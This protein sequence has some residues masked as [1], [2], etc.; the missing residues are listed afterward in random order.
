MTGFTRRPLAVFICCLFAGL[1]TNYA[2][3][4][5]PLRLH[6]ERKF[7]V[8]GKQKSSSGSVVGIETP[9]VLKKDDAYPIFVVADRLEGQAEELTVAEGNVEMRKVGSVIFADRRPTM[10]WMM[11]ST[12]PVPSG[13][14]RRALKSIRR[15]CA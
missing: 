9:S 10:S 4:D 13:F 2:T 11:K 12:L 8:M 14:F 3:A 15:I 5:E 7:N 6:T 1:Q